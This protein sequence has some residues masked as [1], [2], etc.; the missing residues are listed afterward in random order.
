MGESQTQSNRGDELELPYERTGLG[1][2][3]GFEGLTSIKR[4]MRINSVARPR[5]SDP[6]PRGSPGLTEHPGKAQE[7]SWKNPGKVQEKRFRGRAWNHD[8]SSKR[9]TN[10]SDEEKHSV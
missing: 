4:L 2:T 6:R 9:G 3:K 1:V 7:K 8:S 5:P 10:A